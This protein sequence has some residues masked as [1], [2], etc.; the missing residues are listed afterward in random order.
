MTQAHDHK[1]KIP[2]IKQFVFKAETRTLLIASLLGF[3]T[4]KFISDLQ[5]VVINQLVLR[6]I[7]GVKN[8]SSEQI[9]DL[10]ENTSL[11][12]FPKKVS[13]V[14]TICVAI[15]QFVFNIFLIYLLYIFMDKLEPKDQQSH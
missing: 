13:N 12:N 15:L 4:N 10:I 14:T 11:T 2:N 1:H 7:T 5:G 9:D 6:S 8:Y 3:T